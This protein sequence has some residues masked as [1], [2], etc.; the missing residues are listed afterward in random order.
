MNSMQRGVLIAA[1]V[2]LGVGEG[3]WFI[4]SV[5]VQVGHQREL[6]AARRS[7]SPPLPAAREFTHDAPDPPDSHWSH[8]AVAA[9]CHYRMQ[10]LLTSAEAHADI[11]ARANAS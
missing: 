10:P 1:I 2:L 11:D 8:D 9:Y 6:M 4:H 5:Y 3:A 7:T